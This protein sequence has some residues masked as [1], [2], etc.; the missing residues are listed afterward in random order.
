MNS[1][2]VNLLSEIR[3]LRVITLKHILG[4]YSLNYCYKLFDILDDVV[5][6]QKMMR[7]ENLPATAYVLVR[8]CSRPE[9]VY[10]ITSSEIAKTQIFK[11]LR[12]YI[13][14]F[15]GLESLI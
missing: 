12:N 11:P 7:L 4:V 15:T 10:P 8:P 9:P 13:G 5:H 3:I 2:Y 6:P 1:N 14:A